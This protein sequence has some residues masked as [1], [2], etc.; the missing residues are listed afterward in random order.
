LK[1]GRK[2]ISSFIWGFWIMFCL[3][4]IYEAQT[5]THSHTVRNSL[6]YAVRIR[7]RGSQ[8][9]KNSVRG[10]I[11]SRYASWIHGTFKYN[12]RLHIKKY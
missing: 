12:T 7:V 11:Q 1:L 6:W 10:D 8:L 2:L 3:F 4:S 5:L 9:L